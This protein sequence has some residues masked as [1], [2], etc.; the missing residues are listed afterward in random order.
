[1]IKLSTYIRNC[2]YN[3]CISNVKQCLK[4]ITAC[5][6]FILNQSIPQMGGQARSDMVMKNQFDQHYLQ[7][8]IIH[9]K[10]NSPQKWSFSEVLTK[11]NGLAMRDISWRLSTSIQITL[12]FSLWLNWRLFTMVKKQMIHYKLNWIN[13]YDTH[14]YSNCSPVNLTHMCILR[15]HIISPQKSKTFMK[16]ENLCWP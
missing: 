13:T 7:K 3:V 2:I 1:M 15:Q 14:Q 10:E 5:I 4:N 16:T 6:N 9:H 11:C 12:R 8:Y